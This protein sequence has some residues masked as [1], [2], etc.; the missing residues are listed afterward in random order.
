MELEGLEW[1]GSWICPAE[2][3]SRISH[4]KLVLIETVRL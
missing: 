2:V 3:W 1:L 4:I